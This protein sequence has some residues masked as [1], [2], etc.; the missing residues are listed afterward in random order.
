M[1]YF[2]F[3]FQRSDFFV[4]ALGRPTPIYA[5]K[6]ITKNPLN[7]YSFK[8][9]KLHYESVKNDS[10]RWKNYCKGAPNAPPPSLFRVNISGWRGGGAFKAQGDTSIIAPP[11]TLLLVLA[12]PPSP[13]GLS[14]LTLVLWLMSITHNSA[15]ARILPCGLNVVRFSDWFCLYG[16]GNCC[17]YIVLIGFLV[18]LVPC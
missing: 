1:G 9:T 18:I 3:F 17:L 13:L 4:S 11:C 14:Q 8:V 2:R 7:F 12:P 6:K 15:H 5:L 10:A 16:I